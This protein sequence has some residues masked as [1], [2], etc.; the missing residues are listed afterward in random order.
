MFTRGRAPW[1]AAHSAYP[2]AARRPA[3]EVMGFVQARGQRLVGQV[4]GRAGCSQ[5]LNALRLSSRMGQVH[6]LEN[7]HRHMHAAPAAESARL[8]RRLPSAGE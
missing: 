5:G 4:P 1:E 8:A 2:L 6:R 7:T 3:P